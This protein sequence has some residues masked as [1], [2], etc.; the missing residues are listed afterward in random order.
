MPP[1]ARPWCL[2]G[3]HRR[4]SN[5]ESV[6]IGYGPTCRERLGITGPPTLPARASPATTPAPHVEGQLGIPLT[7]QPA[8]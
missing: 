4:L 1:D 2:G 3:C 5:P 7:E 8:A 6:A